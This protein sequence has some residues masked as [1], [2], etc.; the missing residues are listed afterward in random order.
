MC[1]WKKKGSGAYIVASSELRSLKNRDFS[2]WGGS[3]IKVSEILGCLLIWG[4]YGWVLGFLCVMHMMF[5]C[6]SIHDDQARSCRTCRLF[7]SVSLMVIRRLRF[8][9]RFVGEMCSSTSAV[10]SS[11][12]STVGLLRVHYLYYSRFGASIIF[13]EANGLVGVVNSFNLLLINFN[14]F[15]KNTLVINLWPS[16]N[17]VSI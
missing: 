14:Y 5:Q 3:G 15:V 8:S 17:F 13:C 12:E 11:F 4:R 1:T 10:A 6:M 16:S 2:L 9:C 7:H